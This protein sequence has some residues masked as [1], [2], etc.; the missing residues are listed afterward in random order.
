M[1]IF[2]SHQWSAIV[3]IRS[4]FV[5][6]NQ[7]SL[8]REPRRNPT[9]QQIFGHAK[10]TSYTARHDC[11]TDLSR[12]G[13][14]RVVYW[15]APL[16]SGVVTSSIQKFFANICDRINPRM[17][18]DFWNVLFWTRSQCI[19]IF[20]SLHTKLVCVNNDYKLVRFLYDTI[21]STVE[22]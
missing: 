12:G 22:V 15:T 17:T 5:L 16:P 13:K 2:V 20:Y 1:T 3:N 7:H 10:R 19:V 21:R 8:A 9:R 6:I 14:P 4:L 11:G 18:T